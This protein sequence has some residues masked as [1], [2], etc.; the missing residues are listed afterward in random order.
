[1][2]TFL[3]HSKD[4]S[5]VFSSKQGPASTD[6]ELQGFLELQERISADLDKIEE[7][8]SLD[9]YNEQNETL[10]DRASNLSIPEIKEMTDKYE[11]IIQEKNLEIK[12]LQDQLRVFQD[13]TYLSTLYN[14]IINSQPKISPNEITTSFQT[15]TETYGLSLATNHNSPKKT[16]F[17]NP[18]WHKKETQVAGVLENSH[19]TPFLLPD[20]L[21]LDQLIE[22]YNQLKLYIAQL[23]NENKTLKQQ[24]FASSVN[25][26]ISFTQMQEMNKRLYQ[27]VIVM[28]SNHSWNS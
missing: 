24:A 17:I 25:Q 1:M 3:F 13:N 2:T 28:N 7:M 9:T 5:S 10:I 11:N 21:T 16:S 14:Q 27:K 23:H 15:T 20:G 19:F 6:T 18:P 8:T 26:S 12:A 22:Q 4:S